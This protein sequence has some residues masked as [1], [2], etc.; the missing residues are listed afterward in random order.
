VLGTSRSALSTPKAWIMPFLFAA[1]LGGLALSRAI[2]NVDASGSAEILG[3]VKKELGQP[4]N[5]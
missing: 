3:A 2:R 5:S 4:V 1:M